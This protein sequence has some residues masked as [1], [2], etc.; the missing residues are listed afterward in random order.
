VTKIMALIDG[1]IYSQ[2]V[3]DYAVWA[4]AG[5][6]A[7]VG[8]LHVV[9]RRGASSATINFSGTLVVDGR[10]QLLD[11]LASLDEIQ[12]KLTQRR[13]RILLDQAKEWLVEAGVA[14]VTA[15][16]RNGDLIETVLEFEPDTDLIVIGKR[17]EAADF[18]K[19]HLGSNLERVVR[20][21]GKPVLVTARAFQPIKRFLIAFDGGVSSMKAV[22]HI[23]RN[24]LY[25]GLEC[26]ILTVGVDTPKA[27][28]QLDDAAALLRAGGLDVQSELLSGQPDKVVANRVETGG[29]DLLVMGAYGHTRIRSLI[30]GSTTT[31]LIRS[32]MIPVML[33][34]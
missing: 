1:S 18:A 10:D 16:L 32:C 4:T 26:Q 29:I 17:G 13:G 27:R 6:P 21:S 23:A 34:R 22:D 8:L 2:G 11:E 33:F 31:E 15:S 7:T 25:A 20:A 30:I 3:C 19:L 9:G 14:E 5:V 24:P 12:G 28:K